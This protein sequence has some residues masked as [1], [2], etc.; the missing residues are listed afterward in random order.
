MTLFVVLTTL[1]ALLVTCTALSVTDFLQLIFPSEGG[2]SFVAG[3]D[4]ELDTY[5]GNPVMAAIGKVYVAL[6]SLEP[7]HKNQL[8]TNILFKTSF[9]ISR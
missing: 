5:Q 2:V 1:S 9:L 6:A 8:T 4:T 3:A 7:M